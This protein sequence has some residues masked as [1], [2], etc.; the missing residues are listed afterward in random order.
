M[1]VK[2]TDFA[3]VH[4][5]PDGGYAGPIVGF[6]VLSVLHKLASQNVRLKLCPGDE[7]VILTITLCLSS[8]PRCVCGWEHKYEGLVYVKAA[9]TIPCSYLYSIIISTLKL[10]G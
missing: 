1:K 9:A 3:R 4:N 5:S 10:E 8:G 6:L 2:N 7:V